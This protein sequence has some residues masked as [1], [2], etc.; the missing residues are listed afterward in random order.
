MH[1]TALKIIVPSLEGKVVGH[2]VFRHGE[3]AQRNWIWISF[4]LCFITGLHLSYW[5][6]LSH[7]SVETLTLTL[8]GGSRLLTPHQPAAVTVLYNFVSEHRWFSLFRWLL[9]WFFLTLSRNK[10]PVT[11][12]EAK[13]C[14]A[15]LYMKVWQERKASWKLG[16]RS[17]TQV[18]GALAL[19]HWATFHP[20]ITVSLVTISI[21]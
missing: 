21:G 6:L 1:H 10:I 13:L 15:P 19:F 18:N 2:L 9:Q 7:N 14:C 17:P 5:L 12:L 4:F 11:T 3:E 20:Y 16:S 8:S